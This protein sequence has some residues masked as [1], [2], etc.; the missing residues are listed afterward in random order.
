MRSAAGK[1]EEKG[2][3]DDAPPPCL[4][5]KNR[6][7]KRQKNAVAF[8]FL[9]P[10]DQ[11]SRRRIAVQAE[12]QDFISFEEAILQLLLEMKGDFF[13]H[14]NMRAMAE[15]A[16]LFQMPLPKAWSHVYAITHA[17]A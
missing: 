13:V 6:A 17:A 9:P 15:N 2:G 7:E 11:R 1:H 8:S 12:T 14:V 10:L 16:L 5:S 4:S 3:V